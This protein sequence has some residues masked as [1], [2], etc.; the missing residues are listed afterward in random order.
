[1]FSRFLNAIGLGRP[2]LRGWAMYDWGNSAFA[3][4]VIAAVLPP[5]FSSYYAEGLES[6]RATR[7]YAVCLSA[8]L[9]VTAILSPILGTLADLRGNKKR[10]LAVAL[11]LALPATAGLFFVPQGNWKVAA[12]L[13]MMSNGAFGVGLVFYEGLLPMVARKEELNRVSAAGYG[14][15]YLGGGLLLA[16]TALAITRPEVFG[17]SDTNAAIRCSFLA[18]AVWWGLFSLPLF[19]RVRESG[20]VSG[21]SDA[22]AG[23]KDAL[24]RLIS[25][26]RRIRQHRDLFVFL[27]AFWLYND[28]IGTI[29]KLATIFGAEVGIHFTHLVGALLLTQFIA[30]PFAILFGKL[31]DRMG[32][33]R[34]ITLALLVYCFI[35]ILGFRLQTAT[36]FYLLAALVGT[37]QGGAQALSRSLYARMIPRGASG[38]F[39]GFYSI[40]SKF[41]SLFGP[42]LFAA[43]NLL[44]GSSRWAVL[45]I[46]VFF[47][48]GLALLY[49]VDVE[50]GE[51]QAAGR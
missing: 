44:T 40:S 21:D 24:L 46:A 10:Y 17:L 35:A 34:G 42:L 37:V 2:E 16:V 9:A 39:F 19:L 29:V 4:I 20:V 1:M 28:G 26:F 23:L 27:L 22:S 8:T 51:R 11:C 49:L 7:F 15:G 36:D 31:G 48:G 47:A 41:A 12:L 5:F 50:R 38:E 13:V 32:V 30:F 18:V 45:S 25:T 3:T 33:K 43:I 14:L 6:A